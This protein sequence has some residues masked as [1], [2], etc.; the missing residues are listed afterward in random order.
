M[1]R[2][3]AL[4]KPK[5]LLVKL[6]MPAGR[7]L[8]P[9]PIPAEISLAMLEDVATDKQ[10]KAEGDPGRATTPVLAYL[11]TNTP[12]E[13]VPGEPQARLPEPLRLTAQA[14]QC[15]RSQGYFLP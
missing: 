11:L 12:W 6:L 2:N 3:L 10:Q 9:H 15:C 1:S 4:Q 7:G 13:K 14:F 5:I 8:P